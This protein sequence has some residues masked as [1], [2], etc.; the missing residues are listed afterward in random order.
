MLRP[1]GGLKT[2]P[3]HAN[4]IRFLEIFVEIRT[5]TNVDGARLIRR[6]PLAGPSPM[7]VRGGLRMR[8]TSAKLGPCENYPRLQP[9]YWQ[10]PS[11]SQG[12]RQRSRPPRQIHQPLLHQRVL[13]L[14]RTVPLQLQR[15]QRRPRSRPQ[16]LPRLPRQKR[17]VPRRHRTALRHR[18]P[19]RRK[20]L[21]RRKRKVARRQRLPSAL[22][23]SI[24][25][26]QLLWCSKPTRI[27]RATRLE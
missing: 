24:T 17:R 8:R 22:G 23:R 7:T 10:R 2:A 15:S 20:L 6:R 26:R 14:R 12:L 21:A 11:F 5:G 9:A 1:F 4:T 19:I 18:M 27:S 13:R 3:T 25:R 16:N